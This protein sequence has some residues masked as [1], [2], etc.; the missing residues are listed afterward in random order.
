MI[1]FEISQF[2]IHGIKM[3]ILTLQTTINGIK[4]T[5]MIDNNLIG[6]KTIQISTNH[7][8]F[9]QNKAGNTINYSLSNTDISKYS[10]VSKEILKTHFIS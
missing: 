5:V 8:K 4:L 2:E 1:Y 9:S 6:I 10:R 3:N 7:T